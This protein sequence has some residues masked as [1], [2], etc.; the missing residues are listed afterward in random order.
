MSPLFLWGRLHDEAGNLTEDGE[1]EYA[2]GYDDKLTEIV[3]DA[4]Y[5][6]GDLIGKTLAI[7]DAD[8]GVQEFAI[9]ANTSSG[10]TMIITVAGADLSDI[11]AASAEYC[12]VFGE[13]TYH[14]HT[15]IQGNVVAMTDDDGVVVE[16]YEYDLYGRLTSATAW[17]GFNSYTVYAP[18]GFVDM[19]SY[20]I[21]SKID[22]PLLF[23]G[24]RLD[25]ESGLYYFRHRQYDPVHGRFLSRDPLGPVDSYCLYQFVNNNPMNLLDPMGLEL[26]E[27]ERVSLADAT[28]EGSYYRTKEIVKQISAR[29]DIE[30]WDEAFEIVRRNGMSDVME[31]L[32]SDGGDYRKLSQVLAELDISEIK[33]VGDVQAKWLKPQKGNGILDELEKRGYIRKL[34][35]GKP[36]LLRQFFTEKAVDTYEYWPYPDYG[37]ATEYFKMYYIVKEYYDQYVAL[38]KDFPDFYPYL[39][40]NE[41]KGTTGA[42]NT[43]RETFLWYHLIH[44]FGHDAAAKYWERFNALETTTDYTD[45]VYLWR[46]FV[47]KIPGQRPLKPNM[48]MGA[49]LYK[50][51][52]GWSANQ[53]GG[54]RWA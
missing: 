35:Q 34:A 36:D 44:D 6:D 48:A 50:A 43:G 8:T 27:D 46:M 19:D 40:T 54:N 31:Y 22:N 1:K 37:T 47:D 26:S 32:F 49:E 20:Y 53:P 25:S 16:E 33:T 42:S 3:D 14:Y 38:L 51:W 24:R 41:E 9:T 11:T 17:D 2:W 4:G 21:A 30:A 10:G 15:N 13:E 52:Q 28:R 12:I 7:W 45:V 39:G 29:E 18:D 23:Q 5:S